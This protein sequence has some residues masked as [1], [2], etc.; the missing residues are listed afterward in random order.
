MIQAELKRRDSL[1]S[2]AI[3]ARD[4]KCYQLTS[5][6][7]MN[8]VI[9]EM[10]EK[11]N[12]EEMNED[13]QILKKQIELIK[14]KEIDRF[15]MKSRNAFELLIKTPIYLKSDIR[16]VFP[17]DYIIE[18]TFGLRETIG[19]IYSFIRQYLVNP[20]DKFT[21]STTPPPKKYNIL[22]QTIKE[23]KLYP[24]VLMHVNFE[25]AYNKLK[26]EEVLKNLTESQ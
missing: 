3:I 23:L 25:T 19:D 6:F 10:N 21:I 7:T 15:T 8:N 9:V 5:S 13:K 12:E 14:S 11:S 16:L 1:I 17:D 22:H 24:K 4:P 18:V 20:E 26:Q 2:N